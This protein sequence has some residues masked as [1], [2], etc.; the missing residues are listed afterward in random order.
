MSYTATRERAPAQGCMC[1]SE[2]LRS[3]HINTP[4]ER[5]R[6]KEKK[7]KTRSGR[8]HKAPLDC[9]LMFMAASH[10]SN[11]APQTHHTLLILSVPAQ[12]NCSCLPVLVLAENIASG[13]RF[14]FLPLFYCFIRAWLDCKMKALF[15]GHRLN[16]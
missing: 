7:K 14:M 15:H 2:H 13:S 3:G 16:T 4:K 5:R 6:F 10:L 1:T 11:T 12:T 9:L 8:R